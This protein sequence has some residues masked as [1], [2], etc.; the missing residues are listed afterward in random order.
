MTRPGAGSGIR[1]I[2]RHKL[3]IVEFGFGGRLGSSYRF[4]FRIGQF[5]NSQWLSIQALEPPVLTRGQDYQPFPG[6]TRN[7]Q[8]RFQ[9]LVLIVTKVSLKLA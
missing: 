9:G 1:A 4:K 7:G 3:V 2:T 8:R 6:M 5:F